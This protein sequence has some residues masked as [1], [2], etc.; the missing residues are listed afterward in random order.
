MN[1]AMYHKQKKLVFDWWLIAVYI[2]RSASCHRSVFHCFEDWKM[3]QKCTI[4][5]FQAI[6]NA[7]MGWSWPIDVN[8]NHL[9]IQKLNFWVYGTWRNSCK[10]MLFDNGIKWLGSLCIGLPKVQTMLFIH[11]PTAIVCNQYVSVFLRHML[12]VEV[13]K[14]KL[15]EGYLTVLTNIPDFKI[16]YHI[17]YLR[18]P[19]DIISYLYLP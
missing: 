19:W 10:Q 2:Y 17:P 8:R 16:S 11:L 1:T 5:T 18:E 15:L 6:K 12:L 13:K 9:T 3:S 4:S 14:I 7:I